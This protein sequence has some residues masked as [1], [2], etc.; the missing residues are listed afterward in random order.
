L[1]S[2]Y[3]NPQQIAHKVLADRI[4]QRDPG[5]KPKSGDRIKFLYI[6]NDLKKKVLQG[7][8]IETPEFID[9]QRLKIDYSF[10]ITNQLL[11]PLQ[12]LFGLALEQILLLKRKHANIIQYHKDMKQLTIECNG[13]LELFMKKKEI[14]C[15]QQIKALLFDDALIQIHNEKNNVKRLDFYFQP[16]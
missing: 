8:K 10:Y 1:R 7:E 14:Y 15:S 4:A 11:K 16:K 12:Q 2:E 3:K 6:V 9:I 13:D 5:N